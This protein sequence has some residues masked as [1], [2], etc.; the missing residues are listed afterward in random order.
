MDMETRRN[1]QKSL[2]PRLSEFVDSLEKQG[3]HSFCRQEAMEALGVSSGALQTAAWRLTA[4]NRLARPRRDF[5]LIVPSEYRVSGPQQPSWYIDDL[6]K[7]HGQPYYVGLL[8]AGQMHGA[9]HQRPQVFQVVTNAPLRMAFA[10]RGS[11]R[12]YTKRNCEETPT[13]LMQSMYGPIRVSTPEATALDLVRYILGAGHIDNA[14][15]V[16]S[17][18][19]EVIDSEKLLELAMVTE[20]PYV[21][22]LGYLLDLVGWSV[23]ADPLAAWV[24]AQRPRAA[25]L[26]PERPLEDAKRDERWRL[27]INDVVDPDL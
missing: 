20:I 23:L 19:S 7:F 5:F 4:K 26:R 16:L 11:I 14:A 18:L 2:R 9:A 13:M 24:D 3:R 1:T 6:M 15:T 25:L 8:A 22:R 12:F 21:Q 10:G 17:E 27:L